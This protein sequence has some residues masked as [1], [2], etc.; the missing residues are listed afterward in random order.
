MLQHHPDRG[1]GEEPQSPGQVIWRANGIFAGLIQL[2]HIESSSFSARLDLQLS[3]SCPTSSFWNLAIYFLGQHICLGSLWLLLAA[4]D[5][6]LELSLAPYVKSML[7]LFLLAWHGL[8][9]LTSVPS[10]PGLAR[11]LQQ[12]AT[13]RGWSA[14]KQLQTGLLH[15]VLQ[16]PHLP[17]PLPT[18]AHILRCLP[19]PPTES[20]EEGRTINNSDR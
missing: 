8:C 10:S 20:L 3:S 5:L 2:L 16:C 4:L 1:Y 11:P 19:H 15:F 17:F 13:K 12:D 6:D 14:A 9:T 18:L 7:W